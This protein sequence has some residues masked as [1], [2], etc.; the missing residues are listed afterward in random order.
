MGQSNDLERLVAALNISGLRK[1]AKESKDG[2][3]GILA[4]RQI[5]RLM[6]GLVEI[7]GD[8]LTQKKFSAAVAALDVAAEAAPESP[9]VLF[10]LARALAL[11]GKKARALKTLTGIA[12]K[13]L[14][15]REQIENERAFDILRDDPKYKALIEKLKGTGG[16]AG[17]SNRWIELRRGAA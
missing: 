17:D 11:S 3:E 10:S 2:D 5:Q 7:S 14:V 6:V 9:W 1:K 16:P 13:G 4:D 15:R 12:Q 8:L